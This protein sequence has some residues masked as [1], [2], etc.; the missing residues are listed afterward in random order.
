MFGP[1][2]SKIGLSASR[3]KKCCSLFPNLQLQ[4]MGAFSTNA[5]HR[6]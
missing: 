5:S 6:R 2:R 1:I 3:A 4:A